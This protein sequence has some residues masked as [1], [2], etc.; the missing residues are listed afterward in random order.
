[1]ALRSEQPGIGNSGLIFL[2]KVL[3]AV[4]VEVPV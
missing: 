2:D 3:C 4:F 1:M